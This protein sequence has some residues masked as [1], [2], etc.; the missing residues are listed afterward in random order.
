MNAENF[1]DYLNNS[2]LLYQMNYEE[3]RQLIVQ[4]PFNANLRYLL[5]KKSKQENHRDYERNL[6]NAAIH[7]PDRRRLY[8]YMKDPKQL[9]ASTLEVERLELKPIEELMLNQREAVLMPIELP[10]V[11][12]EVEKISMPFEVLADEQIED[13]PSF[14]WNFTPLPPMNPEPNILE[15]P[16]KESEEQTSSAVPSISIP[17]D[18]L[19]TIHSEITLE[20]ESPTD[21]KNTS[22]PPS[23][24]RRQGYQKP[25]LS[26]ILNAPL[27]QQQEESK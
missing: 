17:A 3:L 1:T 12:Q 2:A 8:H 11:Q 4:Y 25:T 6:K 7:S 22:T 26:S 19:P 9:P 14:S 10:S 27:V 24:R 18:D 23:K 21:V 5:A 16:D 13:K 15:S 20:T